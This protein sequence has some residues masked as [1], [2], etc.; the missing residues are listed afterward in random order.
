MAV[1]DT[2][3]TYGPANVTSLLAT[4]LS[5]YRKNLA[6]NIFTQVPLLAFLLD[7]N[8]VTESGGATIVRPVMFS[9]NT[10][11]Q[12]YDKDDVLDTTIQ[13]PYTAAQYQWRLYADSIVVTGKFADIQNQGESQVIDYVKSLIDH[14]E[15]SLKD[16]LD[17]DLFKA[18]QVGTAITPLL[19]IVASSGTVGDINGGTNTWWQSTVQAS[20]S[21]AARG[22]SDMRTV[23]N[24]LV[25]K[26]PV[27]PIDFIISDAASYNAYEATLIPSLRFTDTKTGDLG[28]EN[29]KYKNATWTFDLNAV[30]GDIFM[31]HSK[32]LE[33]VQH[34]K[35]QFILSEWTKPLAQDVKG[36]QIYWAGELTTD[37]RRK[38][39]LLTSVTA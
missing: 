13:D 22:L 25:M 27:G 16:R 5:K 37:N 18:S 15:L 11:A 20:G 39:G 30:A 35:R 12:S 7:K 26:N 24:T 36:A 14:A 8:R 34:T 19:A 33:L 3:F 38:H 1:A 9:K 32:S 29:F 6:D 31:L 4:T 21:F 28:F 10:T 17:Q 23:Y 2:L